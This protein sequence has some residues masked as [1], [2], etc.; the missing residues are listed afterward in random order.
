[1]SNGV[2]CDKCSF[3]FE[4]HSN[5]YGKVCT[6]CGNY[7]HASNPIEKV[8]DDKNKKVQENIRN[9]LKQYLKDKENAN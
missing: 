2:Q 9:Y 8:Y 4:G 1:M 5:H 6:R 3:F 7:I